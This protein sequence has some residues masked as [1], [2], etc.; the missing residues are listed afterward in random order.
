ML[1]VD[2]AGSLYS[3]PVVAMEILRL[4][5]QPK[6]D[7]AAL[8]ACLFA[9][10]RW[11]E[12]C[13][14]SSTARMFGLSRGVSDLNQVLALLG[15]KSVRL[16]VLGFSLPDELFAG[17]EGETLRRYW[18]HT[19]LK[20][21]AA[22][23]ISETLYRLPG[24]EAFIAALLQDLGMLVLIQQLGEPYLR[25]L[26]RTY[27]KSI[28]VHA[29]EIVTLGFDHVQLTAKLLDRWGLPENLVTAIGIGTS[30]DQMAALPPAKRACR[31]YCTWPICS[32]ACWPKGAAIGLAN[33]CASGKAIVN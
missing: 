26:D 9:I 30:S 15:T 2:Q 14:V 12:K 20:A 18:H 3:L 23:E 17:L 5:G 4:T 29:A 24:E 27:A 25:F 32:R 28:D 6:V 10:L 21:T 13:C 7:L 19:A 16:L 8:K 1:F 22:R 33:Y 11:S 31:R